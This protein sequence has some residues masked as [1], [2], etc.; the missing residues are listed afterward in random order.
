MEHSPS[1]ERTAS[2]AVNELMQQGDPD[3]MDDND[4][5][6][7]DHHSDGDSS[8]D[9]HDGDEHGTSLM[10]R[11][12]ESVD[13]DGNAVP[14]KRLSKQEKKELRKQRM[15][16]MKHRKYERQKA[17]KKQRVLEAAAASSST[18]TVAGGETID[19]PVAAAAPALPA[20]DAA[21]TTTTVF[22]GPRKR[23][24][25]IER[26]TRGMQEGI[27]VCIDLSYDDTIHNYRERSSLVKQLTL[28]YAYLKQSPASMHL[29]LASIN[30]TSPLTEKMHK[31]GFENWYASRHEGRP[32]AVWDPS[33]IV[34]L[35]PDATETLETLENDKIY[36]IGG[37]VDRTVRKAA[38]LT[39]AQQIGAQT[40]RL[41]LK[42]HLGSLVTHVL[43]VDHVFRILCDYQETKSWN[44]AIV[45][46]V[47]ARRIQ[48]DATT[49]P[50]APTNI[51]SCTRINTDT[52]DAASTPNESTTTDLVNQDDQSPAHAV[53][54]VAPVSS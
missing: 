49:D 34:I 54:E 39:T 23:D 20:D 50:A 38:T 43:N 30:P 25:L 41:P 46:Q 17:R 45:R 51:S 2:A 29:H 1:E 7:D 27:N 21:D 12:R 6:H 28:V 4:I 36:V 10:K 8:V 22:G 52:T 14:F 53:A 5:D 37:I 9:N 40:R 31:M 33:R 26:L 35:S 24:L 47:P 18:T 15:I 42:E 19:V 32:E 3:G 48:Q 44:E 13:S 11:P 16:E